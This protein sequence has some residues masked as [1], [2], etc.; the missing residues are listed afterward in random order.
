MRPTSY[1]RLSQLLLTYLS[2]PLRCNWC[3]L[4]NS[5][6]LFL[7]PLVV[8]LECFLLRV[9]KYFIAQRFAD[10]SLVLRV[11]G[12]AGALY[13]ELGWPF[14]FFILKGLQR[15]DTLDLLLLDSSHFVYTL[16]CTALYQHTLLKLLLQTW[17]Y[18]V[19]IISVSDFFFRL[20][21][22]KLLILM[23]FLLVFKLAAIDR[24]D[25]GMLWFVAVE[26]M[27]RLWV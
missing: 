25:K 24:H 13:W 12:Y 8:N 19:P 2:C 9:D 16:W 11:I 10:F 23:F 17:S 6:F 3:C 14:I 1:H 18:P 22:M 27:N 5:L 21:L 4:W 26:A 20:A 15:G 7:N